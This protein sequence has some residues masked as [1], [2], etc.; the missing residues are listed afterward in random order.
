M[1]SAVMWYCLFFHILQNEIWDFFVFNF[2]LYILPKRNLYYNLH[3]PQM[4]SCNFI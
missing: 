3:A 2:E 4:I 1:S